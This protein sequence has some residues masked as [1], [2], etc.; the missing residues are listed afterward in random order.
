MRGAAGQHPHGHTPI[1]A[2]ALQQRTSSN[3]LSP[4]QSQSGRLCRAEAEAEAGQPTSAA[5]STICTTAPHNKIWHTPLLPG[6]PSVSMLSTTLLHPARIPTPTCSV[7]ADSCRNSPG[8][9]SRRCPAAAQR[10][11]QARLRMSQPA[12]AAA[13][14]L[15]PLPGA[16]AGQKESRRRLVSSDHA[17]AAPQLQAAPGV[18][19]SPFAT[20]CHPPA[21]T[22][23]ILSHPGL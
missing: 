12:L 10:C 2:S 9:G 19:S 23:L 5:D 3:K 17:K 20:L 8:R 1:Q 4:Q 16:P 7:A 22:W 6:D 18:S 14:Q 11:S 13:R 21:R 15:V